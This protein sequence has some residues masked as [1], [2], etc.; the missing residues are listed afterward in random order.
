MIPQY[1]QVSSKIGWVVHAM[2]VG[3]WTLDA[4]FPRDFLFESA[5]FW[6]WERENRSWDRFFAQV[7][8]FILE[9]VI[10]LV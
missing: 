2:Q 8:H 4:S 5:Y 1:L 6:T 9:D 7:E 10:G 3:F